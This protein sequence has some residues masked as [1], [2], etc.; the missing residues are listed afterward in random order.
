MEAQLANFTETTIISFFNLSR[1]GRILFGSQ[2][3][4]RAFVSLLEDVS[5]IFSK[6]RGYASEVILLG[7]GFRFD[8]SASSIAFNLGYSH[9][10]C[11]F[12]DY[13]MGYRILKQYLV[14]FGYRQSTVSNIGAIIRGFRVP[15]VYK[16][17]GIRYLNE[18]V[19]QKTGKQKQQK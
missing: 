17:K 14:V 6:R 16:A 2:S 4:V 8:P 12:L 1:S 10:I 13:N 5:N 15:D 18:F 7:V 11:I 19:I 3:M 9:R